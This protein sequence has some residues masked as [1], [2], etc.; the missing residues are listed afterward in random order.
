ML[1]HEPAD[2]GTVLTRNVRVPQ[3]EAESFRAWN[4]LAVPGRACTWE[5]FPDA[6]QAVLPK[7]GWR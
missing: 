4:N 5:E 1:S 6:L 7:L 3:Q 2:R